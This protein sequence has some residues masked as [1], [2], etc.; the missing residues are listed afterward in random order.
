MYVWVFLSYKNILEVKCKYLKVVFC[1]EKKRE[2][3]NR[4]GNFYVF[5]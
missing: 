4:E 1:G 2:E 5:F 3:G